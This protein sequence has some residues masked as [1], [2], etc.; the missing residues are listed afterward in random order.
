VLDVLFYL[1]EHRDR[2]VTK[3]EILEHCWPKTYV[4][5]AALT[6]CLAKVRKIVQP[7]QSGPPVVKTVYGRGYYF[8]APVTVVPQEYPLPITPAARDKTPVASGRSKILIVDD[9]PFNVDYLEQELEDLGY[10]TVSAANG[11]EALEKVA[12]EVPDLILLDVM[13]PI[14]DG[15]TVC[16]ILKDHEETRL[17]P[18]IIMTALDAVADRVN[19]IKAGADDFLTKP[20]HEEELLAR[21]DTALKLKHTV[22]RKIGELRALKDHFAKFV[23]LVTTPDPPTS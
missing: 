10:E 20:V 18:I 9:E 23:R 11:Q 21:I 6:R 19:G 5:E 13:M 2:V 7:E 8:V 12:A 22:D 1:L 17:I 14:M 15:F 16:R 4:S 3:E